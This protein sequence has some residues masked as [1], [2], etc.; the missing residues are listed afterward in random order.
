[1]KKAFKQN[2]AVS[3]RLIAIAALV[4]AIAFTFAACGGGSSDGNGGG[5]GKVGLTIKNIPDKAY[6][7]FFTV[8][9]FSGPVTNESQASS[10]DVGNRAL[11]V[12]QGYVTATQP[13]KI[14]KPN[15]TEDYSGSGTFLV[16]ILKS[17]TSASPY[18]GLF[19][20]QVKFTNGNA[21]IDWNKPSY[22]Q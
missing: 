12:A 4:A 13:F 19:F 6:V 10:V 21:T 2:G 18:T 16:F 8:Y 9:D 3:L 14:Y 11:Y 5:S 20:S 22:Q 1:M 17:E 7:S 15:G